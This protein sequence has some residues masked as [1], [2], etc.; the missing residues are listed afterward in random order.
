MN[1]AQGAT[2]SVALTRQR[3][4]GHLVC[5]RRRVRGLD[6]LGDRILDGAF[7]G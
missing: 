1:T 2:E 6:A 3:A 4:V 7:R 5:D